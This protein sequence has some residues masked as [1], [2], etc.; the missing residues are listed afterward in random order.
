MKLIKL[1]ILNLASLDK[2]DGEVINFTEGALGDTSIFSIV[3]Q[4]GSGKSTL[5]DAICLALYN[6]APRYP[7][8]KGERNT[9][10][11][12]YGESDDMETNRL[13]PLD[14]RNI[15]TTGKKDGYSKLTFLANNGNVYRAE[16]H[17]HFNQ[18]RFDDAQTLLYQV[19]NQNGVQSEIHRDWSELQQI[20]GLDYDQFLR[21][22]VIA[23]GSFANFLKAKENERYELLEKIIG[24][25][26]LYNNISAKI[27]EKKD[28]AQKRFDAVK[29]QVDAY[30]QNL[31][32]D[33]E[34]SVL[35]E[36]KV[37]LEEYEKKLD[38]KKLIVEGELKWYADDV[39][40]QTTVAA[41]KKE[42]ES[43][44][45]AWNAI[46]GDVAKL[47][48]HDLISPAMDIRREAK[49]LEDAIES[50]GRTIE[51]L[52]QRIV[53]DEN[54]ISENEKVQIELKS[55]AEAAQKTVDDAIPHIQAA[56][57]LRTDIGHAQSELSEKKTAYSNAES[58]K[59]SADKA[60]AD[61]L[62][63]IA[64]ATN[65]KVEA[66][67]KLK[68]LN[69]EV[70]EKKKRLL[71]AEADAIS[72]LEEERKKIDGL[73]AGKLQQAKDKAVADVNDL[74]KAIDIVEFIDS[75]NSDLSK[76]TARKTELESENA[77]LEEKLK[78]LTIESLS[79]EVEGLQKAYTLMTSESVVSLRKSLE[80]GK[81]CPVCGNIHHV[82]VDGG[83]ELDE[84]TSA[85]KSSLDGK[86]ALLEQQ[87][88]KEKTLSDQQS[89]NL[90]ELKSV[91]T[92]V[93]NISA[94][95]ADS[96]VK[97]NVIAEKHAGWSKDRSV[98]SGMA[99]SLKATKDRC[100]K[101]LSSFNQ[102]KAEIERLD[103][104]KDGASKAK[105]DY[106]V[107]SAEALKNAGI[108]V[109]EADKD[110]ARHQS[111]TG[112]L[113]SQQK[114]KDTAKCKAYDECVSADSK[115]K[116]LQKKYEAELGGKDPDDE[117]KRLSDAKKQ[118]D[119][120][121]SA[122][123]D[124]IAGQKQTLQGHVGERTANEEKKSADVQS[125]NIETDKLNSW[126]IDFNS[127]ADSPVSILIVDDMLSAT[128]NW[129]SIRRLKDSR[130]EALSAASARRVEA[131]NSREEHLKTK[132]NRSQEEIAEE[133]ESLANSS[134]QQKLVETQA[135]LNNHNQAVKEI[136]GK[137]V[138]LNVAT[139]DNEDWKAINESIGG[140]GKMLRKIAQC[141]TLRF[142]IEHANDE[143]R[144][145]NSRYELM[146][147]KNSLGI[148]V[149]DHDRADDIRDTTSL[150][151]GET[152]VVS[153]G[154]AL[155]L[156]ALSSRNISFENLFIDEGF[157]TL[158]QEYL[159][160]VIDSLSLLQMSQG[161]KVGVISHTDTM[162]ERITTQ[163]RCIKNGNSGSSHIE[164]YPM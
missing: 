77:I 63:E 26:D 52:K 137:A 100:E 155:G 82:Y 47:D 90:G 153:L 74:E 48:L 21:T 50:T 148:R 46:K 13:S 49:R 10:I 134:Q 86:K 145:F 19:V 3:G 81:P 115:L 109:N 68:Q 110:L 20:I 35:E 129:D 85:V 87:K 95:L 104:I 106:E 66:E 15:L 126:I 33:E 130:K 43:A 8:V 54:A 141:Y 65:K 160:T 99:G 113:L 120:A 161:K 156:S 127:T 69:D 28:S 27:K 152:F 107:F 55:K 62:N 93:Q 14:G 11:E 25:E 136:G 112:N 80:D 123:V 24:C 111:L 60:V 142:L 29:A 122:K 92:S 40:L 4:T 84:A 146:Q 150:S 133:K 9:K 157:G 58:A 119:D 79:K 23:Q 30:K 116:D 163:I 132:P 36:I 158:D 135:K 118:A 131:E 75:L 16:W 39:N 44:V 159:S 89:K 2:A 114:E 7:K 61:N 91:K 94:S 5:L 6:R 103:E 32:P 140:D 88:T 59:N 97:W 154:L 57:V 147:V 143:I 37:Q 53:A 34:L 96:E 1:E 76:N 102:I 38:E 121:V 162:S 108:L 67:L 18:K 22:V 105:A 144:K 17:V 73:S 42:E 149:I 124:E 138:E 45:E 71:K 101:E 51:Q 72:K 64:N 151:G 164:I 31:L 78:T 128:D 83:E 125:K 139:Q 41:R 12:I 98:L 56:R 117:E 70:A